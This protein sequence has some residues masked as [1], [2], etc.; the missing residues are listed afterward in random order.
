MKLWAA[1]TQAMLGWILIVRGKAGWQE[2][3]RLSGPGLV[4]AL[5]IFALAAFVALIFASMSI[6]LPS[7]PG[8]LAGMVVLSLPVIAFML[9][10]FGTRMVL[11]TDEPVLPLIVPAI[12]VLTAFLLIE[13]LLAMLGGPIVMLAWVA[14]SFALFCL[15]RVA[16]RWNVGVAFCFAVFS[17]VLLVALRL[18]LYM[19]SSSAGITI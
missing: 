11:K 5:L 7:L 17:V 8:V 4:T 14:L 10:L 3:F 15:A 13:G 18:A 2:H 16:T 1:I 12:Y 6:G 9:A 19:L